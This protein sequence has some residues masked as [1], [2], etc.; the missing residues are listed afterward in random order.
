MFCHPSACLARP[1]TAAPRRPYAS[2][3]SSDH[4]FGNN[5]TTYKK[6]D[7][8][9]RK[10]FL[11]IL[12]QNLCRHPPQIFS[13]CALEKSIMIVYEYIAADLLLTIERQIFFFKLCNFF[14]SNQLE[15]NERNLSPLFFSKHIYPYMRKKSEVS[16]SLVCPVAGKRI[17]LLYKVYI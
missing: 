3:V 11:C 16:D 5:L 1:P 4:S 9:H 8:L 13:S 12:S 7:L 6:L 2:V 10:I 14:Y 15:K 17:F